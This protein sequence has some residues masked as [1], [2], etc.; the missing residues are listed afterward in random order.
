[1]EADLESRPLA[2]D[3][4]DAVFIRATVCDADGNPLPD[5]T[6][7]IVFT[8]SGAA[9]FVSPST[10]RAEAGIATVLIRA[11]GLMPGKVSLRATAPG[12]QSAQKELNS[13]R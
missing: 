9:Q 11:S 7:N 4:A 13:G 2:A 1:L 12:L 6:N 10:V 3:G 5:A 8:V